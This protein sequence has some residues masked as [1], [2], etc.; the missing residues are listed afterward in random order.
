MFKNTNRNDT[1]FLGEFGNIPFVDLL[2]KFYKST[3]ETR[4]TEVFKELDADNIRTV[5]CHVPV[6]SDNC[7]GIAKAIK[8]TLAFNKAIFLPAAKS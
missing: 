5:A 6:K 2:F 4:A 3:E 8:N 7:Q 1:A